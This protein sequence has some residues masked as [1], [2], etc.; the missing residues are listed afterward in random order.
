MD[1]WTCG[2]YSC[3]IAWHIAEHVSDNKTLC[4]CT[5]CLIYYL[6][7]PSSRQHLSYGVCLEVKSKDYQNS[8]VLCCIRHLCKTVEL[9]TVILMV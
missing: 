3:V 9:L 5:V 7:P 2:T 6:L 8:S 1:G 4:N